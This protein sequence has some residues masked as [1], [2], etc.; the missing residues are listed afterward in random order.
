M[1]C[2]YIIKDNLLLESSQASISIDSLA[3]QRGLGFFSTLKLDHAYLENYTLHLKRLKNYA[4]NFQLPT[5]SFPSHS[6]LKEW[7]KKMKL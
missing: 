6:L 2:P 4:N 5:P 1:I 7:L 3:L